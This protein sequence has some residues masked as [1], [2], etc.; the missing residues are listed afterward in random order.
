MSRRSHRH[1]S[2]RIVAFFLIMSMCFVGLPINLSIS[3]AEGGSYITEIKLM[4]GDLSILTLDESGYNVIEQSL[5]PSGGDEIHLGF[6]TGGAGDAI[7][8]IIVSTDNGGSI[9][10]DG[11]SYQRVSDINLNSGTDGTALYL[12]V[13]RDESAGE[14]IK[15]ISFFTRKTATGFSD[16]SPL[17]ASD[18]SEVVI[19]D[20]GRVAD[21]DEGIADSSLYLRMYKG[22]IY[23]PY[24]ENVVAATADSE[25]DAIEKLAAKRCTYFINHDI[26]NEKT[27]MIG[28]TRTADESKALRGLVAIGGHI[29][30]DAGASASGS[31]VTAENGGIVIKGVAYDPVDGGKV[32]SDKDYTFYMTRDERAGEPIMDLVA[33]GYDPDEEGL[34]NLNEDKPE[35]TKT[36][37]PTETPEPEE[38]ND[39]SEELQDGDTGNDDGSTEPT[40][41][42]SNE[43]TAAPE[44]Q[45]ETTPEAGSDP[46]SGSDDDT[47]NSTDATDISADNSTSGRNTSVRLMLAGFNLDIAMDA[48]DEAPVVVADNDA[49]TDDPN[50]DDS[51]GLAKAYR[52]YSEIEMKD[53]ISG[54]Y[55]RGGAKNGAKYL[56]DE[57]EFTSASES[58]EKLWLSNIYCSDGGDQ[59]VNYI[60]YVTKPGSADADPFEETVEYNKAADVANG[61]DAADSTASVFGMDIGQSAMLVM[62]IIILMAIIGSL[63]FKLRKKIISK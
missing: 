58:S 4:Q 39:N 17:L 61:Q 60:G 62:V 45:P 25:D 38:Q 42:K 35:A 31:S 12:Y 47:T 26:G 56:Y 5:N 22:N 57:T 30:E 21:F 50:N 23:R 49:D 1:L 40:G 52:L 15:G 3:K 18:G 36:P 16:D 46:D 37:K 6:T 41:D 7:R 54:Y 44:T 63:A 33:C 32:K 11:N 51:S 55:L 43:A 34:K 19:T 24:V 48:D 53:W 8:D 13:S 14:P 10:V 27:V 28:Y 20:K 59:F 9:S 2:V 29:D